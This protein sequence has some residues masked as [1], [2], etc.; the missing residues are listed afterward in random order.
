MTIRKEASV[1]SIAT[2][3]GLVT[4]SLAGGMYM[5][6]VQADVDTL[7]QDA[8]K[9]ETLIQT[10]ATAAADRARI[11][12]RQEALRRDMDT[13]NRKLDKLDDKLDRL[14]EQTK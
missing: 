12:V 5:G 7:K 1:V 9:I 14:L 8:T 10:A 3:I 2:A 6:G 13:A 4:A 11:E